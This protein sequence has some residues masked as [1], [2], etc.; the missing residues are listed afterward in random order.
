MIA[1][2][3]DAG[4]SELELASEPGGPGAGLTEHSPPRWCLKSGV[5][6]AFSATHSSERQSHRT[7]QGYD[8][9]NE[10][11]KEAQQNR[12]PAYPEEAS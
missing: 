9:D 6:S 12:A 7:D 11:R 3:E 4:V 10:G 2:I 1:L 5:S 8:E